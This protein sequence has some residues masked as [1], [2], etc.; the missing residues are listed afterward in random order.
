M[1]PEG[2]GVVQGT[3]ATAMY[4]L[5][6]AID[7]T[8]R[9]NLQLVGAFRPANWF[10]DW[11]VF[12]TAGTM[13]AVCLMMPHGIDQ[14]PLRAGMNVSHTPMRANPTSRPPATFRGMRRHPH[15]KSFD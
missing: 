6:L 4:N 10:M 14:L 2:Y 11:G 5:T 3:E 1:Q 9:R 7:Q 12:K 8:T 15:D 13:H